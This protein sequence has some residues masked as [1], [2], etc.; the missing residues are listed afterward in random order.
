MGETEHQGILA[1]TQIASP[2]GENLREDAGKNRTDWMSTNHNGASD[3]GAYSVGAHLVTNG[4][5]HEGLFRAAIMESGNAIGPPYNGTEWHLVD[6]AGT[7]QISYRKGQIAKVPILLGTDTDEGTSF[8]TT[9]TD[10]DEQWHRAVDQTPVQAV[11]VHG[12]GSDN[13]GTAWML[14]QTMSNLGKSV[15]SHRWNVAALNSTGL[16]GEQ[17]FA[18]LPF[19]FANPLQ[20][21]T[22]LGSDPARL[23]LGQMVARM[24]ASFV[25]DLDP[26]GHGVLHIPQWPRY[27]SQATNFVFRLPRDTSYVERDDYRASGM[28]FI[29]RISR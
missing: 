21:I 7:P 15:Y 12:R 9:G 24:W 1:A 22:A 16:I 25:T 13:G 10:T 6:R 2:S 27:S 5:D 20:N 19:V 18:E 3:S 17:H 26:N 4:G 11:C 29:N 23:H 14:A 8:G 28:D